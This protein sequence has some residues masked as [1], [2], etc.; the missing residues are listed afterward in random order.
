VLW[1]RAPSR[2][3]LPSRTRGVARAQLGVSASFKAPKERKDVP[4]LKWPGGKAGRG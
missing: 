2:R 3:P 4:E 1:K